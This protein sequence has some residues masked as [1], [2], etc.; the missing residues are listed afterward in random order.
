[1]ASKRRNVFQKNK[2]QETTE[3][4]RCNLPPFC[5]RNMFYKKKKQDIKEIG[6]KAN[7]RSLLHR[8]HNKGA[9]SFATL[10]VV[11]AHRKTVSSEVS[12]GRAVTEHA[13]TTDRKTPGSP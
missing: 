11:L 8:V 3:N 7:P 4:G 10:I 13:G 12:G 2:T 5:G 1:M 9:S 6:I